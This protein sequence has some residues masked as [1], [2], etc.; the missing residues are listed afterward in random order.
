MRPNTRCVHVPEITRDGYASLTQAT[1]RASTIVFDSA[2]AY[3]NR[4]Q[5]G[6]DGYSYGL[7]GTPTARALEAQIAALEGTEHCILLPSGLSAITL[8]ML[9]QLR[10]GDRVLIPDSAYPP[11]RKFCSDFL[12]GLGIAHSVYHPDA[13]DL[14]TL[15]TEDVRLIW[16][17]SPG[18]TTMEVQDMRSIAELARG[19]GVLTGCDNTWATPLLLRPLDLGVDFSMQALTKYAGGHSD[20]LMG[21]VCVRDPAFH[22]K[23]RATRT[24]LG[25][26]VSPDDCSLVLR[27]LATMGVRLAHAG[28][29][30][31][32]IATQ[33][34]EFNSV[35]RV[36]H[37]GLSTSE[38]S[39]LWARDAAGVSG[40]FSVELVDLPVEAIDAA[41]DE[42]RIFRIGAS[43]G[44]TH[45]LIA[46]MTLEGR[47]H[48]PVPGATYLRLSI[49]LE[50][51]E[52]L[53]ED[54]GRIFD[55]LDRAL[56]RAGAA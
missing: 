49:G 40:T 5:G 7:N 53:S 3:R 13:R 9:S 38:G 19:R 35:R 31:L 52:D 50:D 44:G 56:E 36:L 21:A 15:L 29:I 32:Q 27:G 6:P 18:S 51:P 39:G 25:I 22:A 20:L 14:E 8:I 47:S 4:K 42:A 24:T 33:L 43:W 41:L 30:G 26:G 2:D 10:A 48:T 45:S 17:E 23:L 46:P 55:R 11:V 12:A 28:R 37:P 1:D 16:M 34:S 54:V